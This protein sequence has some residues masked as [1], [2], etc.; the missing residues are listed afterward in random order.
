ME[1]KEA[2][3]QKRNDMKALLREK[4]LEIIPAING[5]EPIVNE[6][7]KTKLE[8]EHEIL[9]RMEVSSHGNTESRNFRVWNTVNGIPFGEDY[10]VVYVSEAK[11]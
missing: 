2:L 4:A 5:N 6:N 10:W 9:I 3:I 11:N 7:L 1:K 8:E